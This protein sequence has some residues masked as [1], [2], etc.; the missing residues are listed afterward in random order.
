MLSTKWYTLSMYFLTIGK[1]KFR[2]QCSSRVLGRLIFEVMYRLPL[3][4][5][6][7]KKYA[8]RHVVLDPHLEIRFCRSVNDK[9]IDSVLIDSLIFMVCKNY[10]IEKNVK[11]IKIIKTIIMFLNFNTEIMHH[12]Q[13]LW[14]IKAYIHRILK[15]FSWIFI[16]N[17]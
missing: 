17:S 7:K 4:I 15:D 13:N 14:K 16:D 9:L 5:F 1:R 3:R 12:Y 2:I 10:R 11:K 6:K 8:S